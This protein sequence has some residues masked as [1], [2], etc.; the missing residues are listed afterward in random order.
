MPPLTIEVKPLV[1]AAVSVLFTFIIP[2]VENPDNLSPS[3]PG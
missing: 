2:L 1:D 3:Y